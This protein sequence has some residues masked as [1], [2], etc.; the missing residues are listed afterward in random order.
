[1]VWSFRNWDSWYVWLFT[2]C[3]PPI[4]SC[5]TAIDRW[6]AIVLLPSVNK[7]APISQDLIS[8]GK[9]E[10]SI[11]LKITTL[12]PPW[13]ETDWECLEGSLLP[14]HIHKAHPRMY[15][16]KPHVFFT[17]YICSATLLW[18]VH[19]GWL[20]L[21]SMHNYKCYKNTLAAVVPP[22]TIYGQLLK[23]GKCI[24]TKIPVFN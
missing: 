12:D 14:A 23:N 24:G 5:G 1:M 2:S 19:C 21:H 17:I 7:R 20:C 18:N 15:V 11:Q 4:D 8:L 13:C 22:V 3:F 6:E 10:F 16:I 9:G